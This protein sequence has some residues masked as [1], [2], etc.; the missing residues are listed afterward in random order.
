MWRLALGYC[1]YTE[2]MARCHLHR[3]SKG[4]TLIAVQTMPCDRLFVRILCLPSWPLYFHS[5]GFSEGKRNM[6]TLETSTGNSANSH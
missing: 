1:V 2:C 5:R 6:S 4:C 3:V